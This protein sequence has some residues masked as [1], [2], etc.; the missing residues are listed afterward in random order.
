MLSDDAI[1]KIAESAGREASRFDEPRELTFERF[2]YAR[3]MTVEIEAEP[4][5]EDAAENPSELKQEFTAREWETRREP[6]LSRRG[7]EFVS[8]TTAGDTLDE[9]VRFAV[10]ALKA[11]G[12]DATPWASVHVHVDMRD[13][14]QHDV[15]KVLLLSGVNQDSLYQV[16]PRHRY[17]SPFCQ[18]FPQAFLDALE[19]RLR[20]DDRSDCVSDVWEHHLG[21]T[22]G[23][24]TAAW[25]MPSRWYGVNYRPFRT[26]GSL[27]WRMFNE[28]LDADAIMRWCEV[29]HQIVDRGVSMDLDEIVESRD[30]SDFFRTL[31]LRPSTHADMRGRRKK[32]WLSGR[33]APDYAGLP[34]VHP[35]GDGDAAAPR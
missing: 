10:D 16:C 24:D 35:G 6:S 25:H 26:Q 20:D 33:R 23:H 19:G 29:V 17:N 11:A 15:G 4:V 9:E 32:H 28:P 5:S 7:V 34:T 22:M 12:Y 2:P 18:P 31:G 14:S 13:M 3:L 8:P 27:E 21:A 30:W 1:R